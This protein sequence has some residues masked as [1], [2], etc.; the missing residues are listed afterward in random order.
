M[1]DNQHLASLMSTYETLFA[2]VVGSPSSPGHGSPS[3]VGMMG[4]H[5][6][7][8]PVSP[9]HYGG[10]TMYTVSPQAPSPLGQGVYYPHQSPIP[11]GAH[12]VALGPSSGPSAHRES[13]PHHQY[14]PN[15]GIHSPYSPEAS[16]GE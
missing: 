2:D 16:V 11:G 5:M 6:V 7:K 1:R 10:G 12:G 3:P 4:G 9:Q 15:P 13:P 14:Y 8:P